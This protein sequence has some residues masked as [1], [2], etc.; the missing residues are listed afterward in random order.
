MSLTINFFVVAAE[1]NVTGGK[2]TS[3][4]SMLFKA[5]PGYAVDGSLDTTTCARTTVMYSPWWA[6]DMEQSISVNEV[7]ITTALNQSK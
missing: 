3:Q 7:N 2:S 1:A 6:V 4:S 5:K